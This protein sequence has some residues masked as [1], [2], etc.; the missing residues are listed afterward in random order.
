VRSSFASAA[1]KQDGRPPGALTA[2]FQQEVRAIKDSP[3]WTY[4]KRNSMHT[5]AGE[6]GDVGLEPHRKLWTTSASPEF[7]WTVVQQ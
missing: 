6:V 7:Y 4:A 3:S 2:P 5:L 1:V